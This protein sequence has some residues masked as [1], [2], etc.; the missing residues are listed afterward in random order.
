[1]RQVL[2][3]YAPDEVLRFLAWEDA[4]DVRCRLLKDDGTTVDTTCCSPDLRSLWADESCYCFYVPA[5]LPS[6]SIATLLLGASADVLN[7]IPRGP[8]PPPSCARVFS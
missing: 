4:E 3:G 6:L 1:M 7:Y 8:L 2:F 5:V